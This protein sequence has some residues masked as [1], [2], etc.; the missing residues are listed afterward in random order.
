MSNQEIKI[1]TIVQGGGNPAQYIRQILPHGF[2]CFTIMHWASTEGIDF[3][4]TSGGRSREGRL[5]SRLF[6]SHLHAQ[7]RRAVFYLLPLLLCNPSCRL[8]EGS[9]P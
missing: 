9:L 3:K 7:N 1:G 2:E 8:F 6:F 4:K 5:P